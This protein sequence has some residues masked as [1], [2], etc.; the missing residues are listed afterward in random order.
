MKYLCLVYLDA[1][2]WSACNDAECA[3]YAVQI[4]ASQRKL[5][6]GPLH[7]TRTATAVRMLQVHAG[8]STKTPT[9][10]EVTP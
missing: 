1:E 8:V 3:E 6:A 7:P 9:F 2:R 10:A 4:A 5:M